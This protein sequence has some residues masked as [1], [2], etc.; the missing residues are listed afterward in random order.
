MRRIL[1]IAMLASLPATAPAQQ[2][3]KC[4]AG[5]GEVSYQSDPCG[6]G[7]E[8]AKTWEHG[9][10]APAAPVQLPASSRT[11]SG[12]SRRGGASSTRVDPSSTAERRCEAARRQRESILQHE[13]I[14]QRSM[15]LRRELDRRVAEACNR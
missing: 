10:Y 9:E 14:G 13:R 1:I 2:I 15:E 12:S 3:H 11:T 7:R 5:N 4:V 6:D 8:A